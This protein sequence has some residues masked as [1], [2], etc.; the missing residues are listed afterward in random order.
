M[1]QKKKSIVVYHAPKNMLD[2]LHDPQHISESRQVDSLLQPHG[3]YQ[4]TRE[5]PPLSW[6]GQ[7]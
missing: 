7:P 2:G 6:I 5:N 3:G 4:G 1:Q